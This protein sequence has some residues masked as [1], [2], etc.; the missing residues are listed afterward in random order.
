MKRISDIFPGLVS[1]I[2]REAATVGSKG[3]AHDFIHDCTVAGYCLLL[4][5]SE[6]GQLAA[7]AALCHSTD[8]RFPVDSVRQ[9]LVRVKSYLLTASRLDDVAR[10]VVIDAVINHDKP[11]DPDDSNVLVILK[12]ADRLGNLGLVAALRCAQLHHD[13]PTFDPRFVSRPDPCATYE[14]PLTVLHDVRSAL[15]WDPREG[16]GRY[17]LRL[18]RAVQL[19]IP[20]FD[21]LKAGLVLIRQ[22]IEETSIRSAPVVGQVSRSSKS[23]R[24][25]SPGQRTG[26]RRRDEIRRR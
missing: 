21:W 1:A 9:R 12:D 4:D 26:P 3:T 14:S 11:N 7:A 23:P 24:R 8:R 2:K 5:S 16:K 22:Q 19:G 13:L 17:C 18:P 20:Y 25:V 15:E 10:N 6:R